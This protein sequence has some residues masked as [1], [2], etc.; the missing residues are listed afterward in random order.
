MRRNDWVTLADLGSFHF[1][2][3]KYDEAEKDFRAVVALVPDSPLQHRNLGGVYIEM[4]RFM[5]AERELL[6][7]IELAATPSAYSNLG[8]LYIYLGRYPDAIVALNKA[9][10]LPSAQLATN[11]KVW[12]NLAD[13]YRYTPDE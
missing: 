13:A 12:G 11:Y 8:A 9:I 7:S 1:R 6:K 3:Q 2:H 4:G 5:D 10:Q